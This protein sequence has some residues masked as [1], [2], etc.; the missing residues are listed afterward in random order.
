MKFIRF[1]N[2]AFKILG[3]AKKVIADFF[4]TVWVLLVFL[5]TSPTEAVVTAMAEL[6]CTELVLAGVFI[7]SV[8]WI[9]NAPNIRSAQ[10]L[11][12]IF[13]YVL[14][15]AASTLIM[16]FNT[17]TLRQFGSHISIRFLTHFAT[18]YVFICIIRVLAAVVVDCNQDKL[19]QRKR[20]Q[21]QTEGQNNADASEQ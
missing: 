14:G 7:S 9:C 1:C 10:F 17:D 16:Q 6:N 4:L 20:Q 8:F 13:G 11:P 5:L 19:H 2:F 12:D 21:L 18:L 3:S 15:I